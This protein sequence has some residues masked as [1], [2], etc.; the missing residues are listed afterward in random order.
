MRMSTGVAE[1]FN[2]VVLVRR[3]AI[4]SLEIT[5]SVQSIT[6]TESVFQ[7]CVTCTISILDTSLGGFISIIR[8]L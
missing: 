4:E 7:S 2:S 1:Y 3:N 5:D 6:I 8:S